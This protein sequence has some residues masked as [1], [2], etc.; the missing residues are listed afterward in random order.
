MLTL[1]PI[2]ATVALTTSVPRAAVWQA[3]EQVSRWPQVLTELSEAAI[4]PT[5]PLAPGTVISTKA[6]PGRNAIDMIYQVLAAEPLRR[7]VL[8]SRARGFRAQTEYLLEDADDGTELAL[9]AEVS[10]ERLLGRLSTA[11]WRDQH[12]RHVATSLRRRAQAMLTLAENLETT[13]PTTRG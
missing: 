10:A 6:L 12:A 8:V 13:D 3:F 7:L 5:G 4:A 2:H 11:L 1:A 9:T